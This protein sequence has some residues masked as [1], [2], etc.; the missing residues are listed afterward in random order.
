M[1]DGPHF[2]LQSELSTDIP[3]PP[4]TS[5]TLLACGGQSGELYIKP[6]PPYPYH[7][8]I[9]STDSGWHI[10]MTLPHSSINNSFLLLPP[11]TDDP[12]P[13]RPST[14]TPFVRP[15]Y[16]H[17]SQSGTTGEGIA[18]FP[19]TL[20]AGGSLGLGLTGAHA[21]AHDRHAA[22]PQPPAGLSYEEL[23][24]WQTLRANAA[25]ESGASSRRRSARLDGLWDQ[26]VEQHRDRE[27][28]RL[29]DPRDPT[30]RFS[31]SP[32]AGWPFRGVVAGIA[33]SPAHSPYP[34]PA[35]TLYSYRPRAPPSASPSTASSLG[36][37]TPA[38][39]DPSASRL[40]EPRLLISN[41]DM[42]VKVFAIR[43]GVSPGSSS[44]AGTL[45]ELWRDD[46]RRERDWARWGDVPKAPPRHHKLAKVGS[47]KLTTAV[48]HCKE[49]D[50]AL[51]ESASTLMRQRAQP[52]SRPMARPWSSSEIRPMCS[53][54]TSSAAAATFGASGTI[55]VRLGATLLSALATRV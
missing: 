47:L 27:H 20:P 12:L 1:E 53:C 23:R 2:R 41:N 38:T 54:T 45:D 5:S 55:R 32:A 48:N 43:N 33:S 25:A 14:P 34:S 44:S 13:T 52:R 15:R 18:T 6:L 17:A 51:P 4:L 30:H 50:S 39:P 9:V 24:A 11:H 26:V 49:E 31:A 29:R 42:S 46:M 22:S 36:S 19:N 28:D 40:D 21:H 8:A 10:N 16:P 37:M 7:S 35:P 3:H